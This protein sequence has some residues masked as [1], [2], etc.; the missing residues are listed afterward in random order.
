MVSIAADHCIHRNDH[1]QTRGRVTGKEAADWPWWSRS[2]RATTSATSGRPV[3]GEATE[4]HV[5]GGYYINAAQAGDPPGRW[6]GLGA[7]ALGFNPGQL[8][9]RQS[10]DAVYRQVDPRTGATLGRRRSRYPTFAD[11][12][13]RLTAAEP[14]ATAERQIELERE[15]A[16]ATRHPA[17]YTD[18]TVSF[19]K[20]ISILHAAIRENERRARQSGDDRAAAYWA[21]RE[22]RFQEILQ[23][24]NRAALQY[25]QEWARVTRTGSHGTRVDGCETGRFEP[26]GLIVTSWLQGTSRDGDPRIT[27]ITR[28]RGSPVPSATANGALWTR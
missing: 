24:A 9:E 17:A 27:S 10:Y 16:K 1:G 5:T 22:Q 15:A 23:R 13:A 28:S 26:A 25:A 3:Q 12:L 4:G 14:H 11:H 20:S 2:P 19:S 21:V 18:V 7:R 8:V 6:W